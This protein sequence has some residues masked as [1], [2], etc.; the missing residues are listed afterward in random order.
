MKFKLFYGNIPKL[1]EKDTD[2]FSDDNYVCR[3]LLQTR[4]GKPVIVSQHKAMDIWAVHYGFSTIFF[5]TNAEAL[6][7]CSG[8]FYDLDG[9]AV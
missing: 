2:L 3:N 6:A 4:F 5:G 9:K 7:Y 8:R 1:S